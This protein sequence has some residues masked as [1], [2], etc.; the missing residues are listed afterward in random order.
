MVCQSSDAAFHCWISAGV[1]HACQTSS[2]GAAIV[3][4]R[5]TR[6]CLSRLGGTSPETISLVPNHPRLKVKVL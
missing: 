6:W 1:V 3:V 2:M 5:V 4:S